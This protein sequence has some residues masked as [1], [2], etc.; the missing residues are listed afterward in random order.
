MP[1]P[2]GAEEHEG[3]HTGT[4]VD[5][6]ALVNGY[7]PAC[8]CLRA[9][10]LTS[11]VFIIIRVSLGAIP[12]FADWTRVPEGAMLSYKPVTVYRPMFVSAC[13]DNIYHIRWSLL[14]IYTFTHTHRERERERKTPTDI[15]TASSTRRF[16]TSAAAALQQGAWTTG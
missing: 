13:C 5:H 14:T 3:H 10:I 15:A 8:M 1:W 9:T 2:A 12:N 16:T 7:V 4:A 11:F 6:R